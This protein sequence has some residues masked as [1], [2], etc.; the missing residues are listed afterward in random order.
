VLFLFS[1]TS[2]VTFVS[3]DF[4]GVFSVSIIEL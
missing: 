3:R 1:S 4:N 2:I